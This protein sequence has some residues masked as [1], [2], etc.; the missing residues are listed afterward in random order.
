MILH[1]NNK[2]FLTTITT[3]VP[4]I[5]L[6]L[7]VR[8]QEG[9]PAC[10]KTECWFVGGDSLTGA[11]PTP[12]TTSVFTRF[13]QIQLKFTFATA[14]ITHAIP[15]GPLC[16]I[17]AKSVENSSL[18]ITEHTAVRTIHLVSPA[19]KHSVHSSNNETANLSTT[20]PFWKQMTAGRTRI[21]SLSTKNLA[22]STL[23]FANLVSKC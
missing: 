8:R 13:W 22:F 12:R 4:I 3:N 5:A 14:M 9:H 19:G 6:T 20:M 17:V 11:L 7:L 16:S 21:F 18:S 2:K 23:I 1:N 15:L 10:N